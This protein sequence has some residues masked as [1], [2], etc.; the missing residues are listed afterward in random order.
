MIALFNEILYRP[1]FN[2]VIF[3]Y[4]ILPGNDFGVAIIV[5]TIL[6]RVIFFPLSI[7]TIRSQRVLSKLNPK[8]KEIKERLKND[9]RAQSAAIVQLYKESKVN[10]LGGC[11]PLLIQ[12]PILIALYR[13]FIAGFKPESLGMLYGFIANPGTI[14]RISMGFIDITSRAPL[15]AVIAGVAQFFQAKMASS[16]QDLK[17]QADNKEMA[18]INSQML[19]F[20][21]IMVIIIGWNL[22]A[23]LVLYW[24]ITTLFSFLEQLYVKWIPL[25]IRPNGN[26]KDFR[27]SK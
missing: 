17:A 7:K 18:A 6:I 4:N 13:A 27:D 10:P 23:G 5:L 14:N 16:S 11:L 12:I 22:P 25:E 26:N 20:M 21:P 1:L 15:M 8:M 24:I 3:L 9:S 2:L 19:Y